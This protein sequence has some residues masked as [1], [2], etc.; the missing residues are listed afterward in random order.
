[1]VLFHQRASP[2]K[3]DHPKNWRATDPSTSGHQP[4]N[5]SSRRYFLKP[6]VRRSRSRGQLDK[7][8]FGQSEIS[9]TS[10]SSARWRLWYRRCYRSTVFPWYA[11]R[12]AVSFGILFFFL[13]ASW[14]CTCHVSSSSSCVS[15]LEKW[16]RSNVLVVVEFQDLSELGLCVVQGA[17]RPEPED[18][19]RCS[20]AAYRSKEESSKGLFLGDTARTDWHFGNLRLMA[21]DALD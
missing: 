16:K 11:L 6:R 4:H 20:S 14:W 12:S 17:A 15:L 18:C 10:S 7:S 2:A 19:L 9:S 21:P 8:P 13:S 1:M 3:G 5:W